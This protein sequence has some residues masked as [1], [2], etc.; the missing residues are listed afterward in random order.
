MKRTLSPAFL[1]VIPAFQPD[2]H[3]VDLV[4]KLYEHPLLQVVIVDDGSHEQHQPVFDE[5][6]TMGVH[7]ITHPLN[8]GKGSALKTGL[9]FALE[10][11]P[12]SLGV[13]TADAD[14]QHAVE[15]IITCGN[16]LLKHPQ[17][18][19]IGTRDFSQSHVPLRSRLG[20]RI[21]AMVHWFLTDKFIEDTQTGLRAFPKSLIP[22]ALSIPG[23]RFEYE[24]NL[25]L[26]FVHRHISIVQMPIQTI[27]RDHNSHSHFNGFKDSQRVYAQ[28]LD[29]LQPLGKLKIM[30]TIVEIIS[31]MVLSSL[32]TT[33][34]L[35]AWP[36]VFLMIRFLTLV[37]LIAL[38]LTQYRQLLSTNKVFRN[39][40][41][42]RLAMAVLA[43][44]LTVLFA[45]LSRPV[46]VIIPFV[47][48]VVFYGSYHL[49]AFYHRHI[50]KDLSQ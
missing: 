6:T 46:W 34:P 38:P 11:Y 45:W 8:Q 9:R 27:Y 30:L 1:V 17:S 39:Y 33:L 50:S 31:L 4:I 48:L 44:G 23:D 25:L 5:L 14:G 20:N 13:V 3:L 32:A 24:M 35:W 7:V 29:T 10:T 47:Q 15:D 41:M 21:T 22:T 49:W 40:I 19:I 42:L 36:L 37:I 2:H 26:E 18:L 43:G 12:R 16:A 28:F